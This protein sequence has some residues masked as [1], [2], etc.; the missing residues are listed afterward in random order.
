MSSKR[1]REKKENSN[2]IKKPKVYV[3]TALAWILTWIPFVIFGINQMI[4]D[5]KYEFLIIFIIIAVFVINAFFIMLYSINFSI[6]FSEEE[7][8]VTN[9][10]RKTK[11]FNISELYFICKRGCIH[12]Y[13]GKKCVTKVHR[14]DE[15]FKKITKLEAK[16][17][18]E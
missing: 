7:I 14:F 3:F 15:N 9:W 5:E 12:V 2:I 6:V 8:L 18:V 10:L 16:W 1:K 13:N 11:K 4:I 17:K